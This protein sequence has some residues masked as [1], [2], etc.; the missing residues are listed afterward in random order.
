MER[1]ASSNIMVSDYI[2]FSNWNTHTHVI[3]LFV[4]FISFFASD[5][6]TI[7]SLKK[8][9]GLTA[10]DKTITIKTYKD[11]TMQLTP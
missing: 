1:E 3:Y 2:V 9:E 8:S 5:G 7:H 10:T 6:S 4:L 11:K